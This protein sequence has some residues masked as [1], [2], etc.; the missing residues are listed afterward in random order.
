MTTDQPAAGTAPATPATEQPWYAGHADE[1]IR[2]WA[3]NKGWKA[4]RSSGV[5]SSFGS[6]MVLPAFSKPISFSRL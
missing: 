5:A 1:N 6:T 3:A 4:R 2:N